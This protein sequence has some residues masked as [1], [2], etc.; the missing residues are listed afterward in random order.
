MSDSAKSST[1]FPAAQRAR[2]EALFPEYEDYIRKHNPEF[3]GRSKELTR[4]RE[5]TAKNFLE[6][7]QFKELF[8]S[9][10]EVEMK[11]WEDVSLI[12]ISVYLSH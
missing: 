2:L 4:W 10:P 1:R 8:R 11:D 3:K 7:D 5:T 6:D 9:R 12:I